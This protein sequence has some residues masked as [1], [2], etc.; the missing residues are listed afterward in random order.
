MACWFLQTIDVIFAPKK[1]VLTTFSTS[2][3][4]RFLLSNLKLK[5]INRPIIQASCILFKYAIDQCQKIVTIQLLILYVIYM[6]HVWYAPTI[7]S[8][9]GW[10]FVIKLFVNNTILNNNSELILIYNG[11]LKTEYFISWSRL[12]II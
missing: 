12:I 8:I 10:T 5:V 7:Y 3:I 1:H 9:H 11:L 2:S 4:C 6:T